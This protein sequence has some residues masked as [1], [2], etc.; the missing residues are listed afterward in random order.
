MDL[1]TVVWFSV[2]WVREAMLDAVSQR[3]EVSQ[4]AR[5]PA[6]NF[7]ACWSCARGREPDGS[8]RPTQPNKTNS[9]NQR[10]WKCFLDA[11]R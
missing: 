7:A 9:M 10:R 1:V 5:T 2:Q 6:R 4:A 8:D 11:F 3:R